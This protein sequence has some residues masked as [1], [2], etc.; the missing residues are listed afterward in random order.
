MTATNKIYTHEI[1]KAGEYSFG[2]AC[3]QSDQ[4]ILALHLLPKI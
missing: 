3:Y 2:H 1:I 4:N